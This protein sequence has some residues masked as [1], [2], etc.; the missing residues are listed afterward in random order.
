MASI[1][2]SPL[3]DIYRRL[4]SLPGVRLLG[5]FHSHPGLGLRLSLTDRDTQRALFD[6]DWQVALVVDPCSR[7]LRFYQG[8]R[9]RRARWVAVAVTA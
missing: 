5:W 8:G 3:V 1:H 4:D 7:R 2:N 9:A 6:A